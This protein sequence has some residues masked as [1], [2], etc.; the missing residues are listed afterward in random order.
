MG[1][2]GGGSRAQG[3]GHG[4]QLPN[5]RGMLSYHPT[6]RPLLTRPLPPNPQPARRPQS[7]TSR[8]TPAV[9]GRA[10]RSRVKGQGSKVKDERGVTGMQQRALALTIPEPQN[11]SQPLIP[12]SAPP[13][14]CPQSKPAPTTTGSRAGCASSAPTPRPPSAPPRRAAVRRARS[15]HPCGGGGGGGGGVGGAGGRDRRARHAACTP[16]PP[17]T[18]RLTPP[19]S[20]PG[21]LYGR[22]HNQGANACGKRG[23][24]GAGPKKRKPAPLPAP[25]PP[26]CEP[27]P[28]APQSTV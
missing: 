19:P 23:P 15:A 28:L 11:L 17:R 25:L 12:P 7:G 14:A 8:P 27:A 24:K 3:G 16:P 13:P 6:P 9:G 21:C 4:E 1:E 2:A 20:L 5:P 22:N 26:P 10:G 18:S